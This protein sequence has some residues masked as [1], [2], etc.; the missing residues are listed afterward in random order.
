M[1]TLP[2]N[3]IEHIEKKAEELGYQVVDTAARSGRGLTIEVAIDKEGGITLHECGEFNMYLRSWIDSEGLFGGNYTID[4]ASP[5]LDRAL[6]SDTE[7][8]WAVGKDV[9]VSTYESVEEVKTLEG[10]LLPF[11]NNNCITLSKDGK[12]VTI[13][14]KNIARAK[15]KTEILHKKREKRD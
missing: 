7:F 1:S 2:D 4:V 10:K 14:R 12:D 13:E 9:H 6:K 15:I 11:E 8:R 5:G 3:L